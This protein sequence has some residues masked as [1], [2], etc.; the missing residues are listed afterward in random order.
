MRGN[1][2]IFRALAQWLHRF[3]DEDARW[4]V[5]ETDSFSSGVCLGVEKPLPRCPQVAPPK[6]KHRRLDD[7]EFSPIA[8]NYPS[9]QM[10]VKELES[11]F[12]EEEGLGRMFPTKL[13]VAEGGVW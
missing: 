4:L 12:R 6:L 8:Q 2:F 3:E 1:P 5:D 10:S 11:K 9:A 13:G 7:T